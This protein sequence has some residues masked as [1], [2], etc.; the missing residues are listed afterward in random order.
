VCE[1]RHRGGSPAQRAATSPAR[2]S[3]GAERDA[4]TV[5]IGELPSIVACGLGAVL[6]RQ[7]AVRVVGRDLAPER[8]ERAVAR[9]SPSVAILSDEVDHAMIGRLQAQET[10]PGLL[11][12]VRSPSPLHVSMLAAIGA[13]YFT[14]AASESGILAAVESLAGVQPAP[15]NSGERPGGRAPLGFTPVGRGRGRP[16]ERA[17]ASLSDLLTPGERRVFVGLSRGLTYVEI[18]REL[19]IAPETVRVH[20]VKICRKVNAKGKR[21]LIGRSLR[22]RV[23][24]QVG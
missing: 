5:V 19:H 15:G 23:D 16:V 21:D 18:G 20:A 2:S 6:S 8:L 10:P 22:E 24:L 12:L 1:E 7:P 17:E 3:V 13:A 4:V 14:P 11:V 9:E